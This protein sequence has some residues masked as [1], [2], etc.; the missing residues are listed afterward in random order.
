MD[1]SEMWRYLFM[2][3]RIAHLQLNKVI[4][5][6]IQYVQNVTKGPLFVQASLPIN[7]RQL[8]H[9]Q[10]VAAQLHLMYRSI[11]EHKHHITTNL[12]QPSIT[13]HLE[14]STGLNKYNLTLKVQFWQARLFLYCYLTLTEI[15]IS[16]KLNS[17]ESIP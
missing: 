10:Y 13:A 4:I 12:S 2:N 7:L 16:N 6:K 5:E 11:Q 8:G 9:K 3:M 1:V 17:Q 14:H 15:V